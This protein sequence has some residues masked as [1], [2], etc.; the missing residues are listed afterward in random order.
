MSQLEFND[1]QAL[2]FAGYG[3]LR[4]SRYVFLH[5]EEAARARAWLRELAEEVTTEG[6]LLE[7]KA[8]GTRLRE[9]VHVAFTARGLEALGLDGE[10]LGTFSP[11]FQEGMATE[12]RSR[13]LGDLGGSA[14]ERWEFGGREGEESLHLVLM[15]FAEGEVGHE[16][17]L[18][19]LH[20]RHRQR[21]VA[22]GLRE[23]SV[24]DAHLIPVR[25]GDGTENGF[26]EPFGF[27]DGIAQPSIE[28]SPHQTGRT[29]P[30]KAGEFILG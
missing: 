30:I 22:H 14:P 21:Y 10:V 28:G 15:L 26:R 24:Q 5:L 4:L 6:L 25:Q 13:I 11:E 3:S 18:E 19:A 8:S 23:V 7:A 2:V 9:A 17:A 29:G 20:A 12:R 1:I 27:R 16:Q